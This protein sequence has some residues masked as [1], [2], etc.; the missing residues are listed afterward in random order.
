MMIAAG[1][2]I[3]L[4]ESYLGVQDPLRKIQSSG[5]TCPLGAWARA[6]VFNEENVG[7]VVLT[8]QEKWDRLKAIC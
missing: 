8:S 3:S 1:H 6:S 5:G 2:A 7:L 4:I